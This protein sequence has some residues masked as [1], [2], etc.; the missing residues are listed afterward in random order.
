MK[1]KTT[2]ERLF[3]KENVFQWIETLEEW[4]KVIQY[5]VD[6]CREHKAC[7]DCPLVSTTWCP[8]NTESAIRKQNEAILKRLYCA[9]EKNK[10]EDEE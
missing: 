3:N 8:I 10:W 7:G 9:V 6:I 4:D 2:T 5:M 1:L